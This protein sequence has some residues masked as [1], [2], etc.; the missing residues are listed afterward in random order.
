MRL[1]FDGV[2]WGGVIVDKVIMT[3]SDEATFAEAAVGGWF[4]D[5]TLGGLLGNC[6]GEFEQ[7][8]AID[9]FESASIP[10]L[11]PEVER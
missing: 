7:I 4:D 5:D 2:L 1:V 8:L 6:C 3:T 11:H 10:E 9:F